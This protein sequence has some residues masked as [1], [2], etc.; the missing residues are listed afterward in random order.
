MRIIPVKK[1]TI[2]QSRSI[3]YLTIDI[4]PPSAPPNPPVIP[5]I[6]SESKDSIRLK[7]IL[8][9]LTKYYFKI[10]A[11]LLDLS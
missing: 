8:S 3:I 5:P 4:L 1:K 11:R 10:I 7:I 6:A 9:L 2:F